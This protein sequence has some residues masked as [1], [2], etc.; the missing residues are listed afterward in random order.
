MVRINPPPPQRPPDPLFEYLPAKSQ[1]LRIFDPTR[2]QTQALTFRYY[3]PIHRFDHQR[4]AVPQN[5]LDRGIYYAAFTLSGCV[6]ETFG[7][8]GIIEIKAQ[9][10]AFMELRRTLTL[11]DL[12]GPGAMRAGS[13]A[14]LAK[15]ADRNLSQAWSCYF[16]EAY[17]QIDGILYY[18]AHNDEQSMA[19]YERAASSL[20]C[21]QVFPLNDNGLRPHLQNAALQNNLSF[22]Q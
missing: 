21:V 18:N 9:Q 5:D 15:I 14:A 17:P 16:Y 22:F 7:D 8:T 13:V 3:G 6:V 12:R 10:L 1:I 20:L 11:L 2:H 19:L 4:G